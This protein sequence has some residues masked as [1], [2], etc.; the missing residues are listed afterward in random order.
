MLSR[1]TV[2]TQKGLNADSI[3]NVGGVAARRLACLPRK[4]ISVRVLKVGSRI[5]A[6]VAQQLCAEGSKHGAKR[7]P[8]ENKGASTASD[9]HFVSAVTRA[10]CALTRLQGAMRYR[11]GMHHHHDWGLIILLRRRV[12]LRRYVHGFKR[13]SRPTSSSSKQRTKRFAFTI[14]TPIQAAPFSSTDVI[15]L[16]APQYG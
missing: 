3:L 7:T 10:V 15:V 16:Q 4:R 6:P 1:P 8:A 5:A 12:P 13:K 14:T 11:C 2:R 9:V